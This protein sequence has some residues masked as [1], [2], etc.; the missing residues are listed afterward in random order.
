MNIMFFGVLVSAFYVAILKHCFSKTDVLR[1]KTIGHFCQLV[2][3]PAQ[4]F[5]GCW[6]FFVK[7]KYGGGKQQ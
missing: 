7:I 6:T 1:Y 4:S 3:R 2:S 5:R